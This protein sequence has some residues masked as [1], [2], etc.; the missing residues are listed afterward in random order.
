M[1]PYKTKVEVSEISVEERMEQIR[2]MLE[3]RQ[4]VLFE[5]LCMDCETLHMLITT[6][7]AVLELVHENF[8]AAWLDEKEQVWMQRKTN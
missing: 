2:Q 5:T 8:L 4:T 6:F 3:G 1:E 7:L